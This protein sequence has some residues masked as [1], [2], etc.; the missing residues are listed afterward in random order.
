ML[1]LNMNTESVYI[2]KRSKPILFGL[3]G[4]KF[5]ETAIVHKRWLGKLKDP[6]MHGTLGVF[7]EEIF[8][9]NGKIQSRRL[10]VPRGEECYWNRKSITYFDEEKEK[11]KIIDIRRVSNVDFIEWVSKF[12]EVK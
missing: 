2:S 1:S 11:G 7:M 9:V 5:S 4:I 6:S 10:S 8:F 3:G 12:K